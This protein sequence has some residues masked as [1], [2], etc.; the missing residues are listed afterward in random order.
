MQ[1][2][3]DRFHRYSELTEILRAF[4]QRRPDL[5]TLESLGRSHEG[6]DIWLATATHRATGAASDKPAFWID[7][8]IHAAELTASTACLHFLSTLEQG[9]GS[10]PDITRLLDT[11]ALYVCPRINPDGAEWALADKPSSSAPPPARIPSTRTRSTAERRGRRRGRPHP[12]HA[13]PDP[14]GAFKAH[15]DDARLM[16][17]RDPV[18]AGGRYWRII[19]EGAAHEFRR[20]GDPAQSRQGGPRPQPQLSRRVAAGVPA[21]RRAD[22]IP[23][24]SP[25]CA[26]VVD[27]IVSTPTSA[28]A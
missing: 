10:D 18:E 16:I 17:P 28:P 11:R 3:L 25:R 8:N 19:P 27:F 24:P 6:R 13:H 1:P 20:R 15:P 23:P 7:G 21:G 26:R 5:F 22:P 12:V 9:Y 14:N 2:A 4:A